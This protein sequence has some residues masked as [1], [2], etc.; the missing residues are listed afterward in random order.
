M[1][2]SNLRSFNIGL[3]AVPMFRI[4]FDTRA[5]E[6]AAAAIWSV[7]KSSVKPLQSLDTSKSDLNTHYFTQTFTLV[8]QRL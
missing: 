1:T 3:L 7:L 4:S 6:V 8:T 5:F 2:E